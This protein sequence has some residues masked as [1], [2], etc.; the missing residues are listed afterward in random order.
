M[1][2]RTN[3]EDPSQGQGRKALRLKGKPPQVHGVKPEEAPFI[4]ERAE[5]GR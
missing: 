4:T 1:A 2:R 5:P 3:R